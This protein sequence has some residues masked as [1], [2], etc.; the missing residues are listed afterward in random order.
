MCTTADGS[1]CGSDQP[2]LLSD[3]AF[4]EL[5]DQQAHFVGRDEHQKRVK[6]H[7]VARGISFGRSS[8]QGLYR[9]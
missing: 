1:R 6:R 4:R 7:G 9:T 3:V 5:I 2:K 8:Q